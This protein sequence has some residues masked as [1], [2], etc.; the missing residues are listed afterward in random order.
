LVVGF[1]NLTA[2]HYLDA[3]RDT[4]GRLREYFEWL[5]GADLLE[6]AVAELGF[7]LV[8]MRAGRKRRCRQMRLVKDPI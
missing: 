7:G 4:A 3:L 2:R 5:L 8:A 6:R 1:A